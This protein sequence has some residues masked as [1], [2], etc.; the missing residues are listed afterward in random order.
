MSRAVLGRTRMRDPTAVR[1][2]PKEHIPLRRA[3]HN[4]LVFHA[5]TGFIAILLGRHI[6]A[7]VLAG[8]SPPL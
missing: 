3:R 7:P 4:H 1:S 6:A 5:P 2:A 8:A